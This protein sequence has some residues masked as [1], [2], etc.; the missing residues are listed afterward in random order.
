MTGTVDQEP[1]SVPLAIEMEPGSWRLLLAVPQADVEEMLP[2]VRL[3]AALREGATPLEYTRAKDHF[4]GAVRHIAI[5]ASEELGRQLDEAAAA[6]A[7]EQRVVL[8]ESTGATDGAHP[9][10]THPCNCRVF[11]TCMAHGVAPS[12]SK[13]VRAPRCR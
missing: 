13:A 6:A 9:Q 7:A 1:K 12:R 11:R 8:K 3:A 4:L 2:A 5:R 10:M